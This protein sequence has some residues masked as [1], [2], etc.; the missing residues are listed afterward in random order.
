M[1]DQK[2]YRF[3]V[4]FGVLDDS[5]CIKQDGTPKKQYPN[6]EV[7]YRVA[8]KMSHKYGE[9]FACYKCMQCGK[10]HVG[11]RFKYEGVRK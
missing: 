2:K 11:R 8:C 10:Y 3:S 7:A 4:S 1:K 5:S 6:A 9:P